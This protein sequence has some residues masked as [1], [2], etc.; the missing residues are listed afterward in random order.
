MKKNLYI[1]FFLFALLSIAITLF[2]PVYPRGFKF[3]FSDSFIRVNT[4][5]LIL[6]YVL[7]LLVSG[8]IYLFYIK[9]PKKYKL[10]L[11]YFSLIVFFTVCFNY[12]VSPILNVFAPS[13]IQV[14][15]KEDYL[16]S[17][18]SDIISIIGY[19]SYIIGEHLHLD[20]SG[21]IPGY[22]K[23][24]FENLTLPVAFLPPIDSFLITKAY[25]DSLHQAAKL[26][27]SNRSKNRYRFLIEH[28]QYGVD[29]FNELPYSYR[30]YYN[31]PANLL[32]QEHRLISEINSLKY[33]YYKSYLSP[34]LDFYNLKNDYLASK[35]S[36]LSLKSILQNS[37]TIIFF[38]ALCFVFYYNKNKLLN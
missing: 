21:Q 32:L 23:Y 1:F 5:R 31:I 36:F 20:S 12:L 3:L 24:L 29:N 4:S 30:G 26:S 7:A 19:R 11:F 33:N 2:P 27:Q 25:N 8:I 38:I 17:N 16:K 14:Q 6:E 37:F 10:I 34:F 35:K 22:S 9:S 28:F 13:Y 15:H 18:F